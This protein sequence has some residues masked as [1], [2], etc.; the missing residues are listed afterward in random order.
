MTTAEEV[1]LSLALAALVI[2]MLIGGILGEHWLMRKMPE[3]ML[4]AYK[5]T[6]IIAYSESDAVLLTCPFLGTCPAALRAEKA[7]RG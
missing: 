7:R 3:G 1:L 4:R 5:A 2:G 6:G